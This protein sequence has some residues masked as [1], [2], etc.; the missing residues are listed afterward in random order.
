M[1]VGTV[2]V[3]GTTFSVVMNEKIHKILIGTP[4]TGHPLDP[5]Q[6]AQVLAEKVRA[7]VEQ[8]E[9]FSYPFEISGTPFQR[10]IYEAVQKIPKGRVTTYKGVAEKIGSRAFRAVGQALHSNPVPFLVPCH[11]VIG[12][13]R[14]LTG[15]GGG[16]DLKRTILEKEGVEFE[17]KKVKKIYIL[18]KF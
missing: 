9:V 14:S 7:W 3:D 1:N 2:T 11:R 8:G 16:V 15:F 18:E 4:P 10:A 5:S 12:S 17:G 13:D 6:K